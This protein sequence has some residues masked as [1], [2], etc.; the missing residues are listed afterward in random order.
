MLGTTLLSF[1]QSDKGSVREDVRMIV[2]IGNTDARGFSAP[3]QPFPVEPGVG[4]Y[5]NSLFVQDARK[6]VALST[7]SIGGVWGLWSI[8]GRIV[9]Q[10]GSPVEQCGISR[11]SREMPFCSF[12]PA[13]PVK[14]GR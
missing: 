11:L 9:E 8:E 3:S 13:Q 6:V 7:T 14:D 10:G 4:Q 2:C 5:W 1:Q 12:R